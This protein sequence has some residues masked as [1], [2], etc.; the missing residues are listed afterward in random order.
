MK[1][2][3][4]Y[5]MMIQGDRRLGIERRS[6]EYSGHYPERRMTTDRRSEGERR[7]NDSGRQLVLDK[8]YS[9]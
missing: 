5:T 1:I 8:R 2:E 9:D 3:S 4:T 7:S 6:Y